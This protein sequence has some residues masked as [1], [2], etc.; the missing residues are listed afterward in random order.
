M[1]TS[2]MV[3]R[4][5]DL[6]KISIPK[7][8]L[9]VAGIEEGDPLEIFVDVCAETGVPA[10]VLVDY[11]KLHAVEAKED[12]AEEKYCGLYGF[13]RT[14]KLYYDTINEEILTEEEFMDDVK[15]EVDNEWS[16]L[17]DYYLCERFTSHA[18]FEMSEAEKIPLLKEMKETF[19]QDII[20]E[21]LGYGDWVVKE[22]KI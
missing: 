18:L 1:K 14:V 9:R 4:V 13:K 6:R 3:R 22:I 20:N 5:D 21:R 17:A 16:R 11:K 12:S 2:G 19:A 10:I 8:V 15:N 7:E